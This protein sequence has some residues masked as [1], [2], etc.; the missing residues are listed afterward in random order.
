MTAFGVYSLSDLKNPDTTHAKPRIDITS[1][2]EKKVESLA[3]KAANGIPNSIIA[4]PSIILLIPDMFVSFYF[5]VAQNATAE[6]DDWSYIL[7]EETLMLGPDL[8]KES[9]SLGVISL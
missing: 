9:E 1:A 5:D 7:P 2:I 4:I 3:P 8:E 6:S